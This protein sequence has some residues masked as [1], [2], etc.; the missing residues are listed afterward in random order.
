M[1]SLTKILLV[2][3]LITSATYTYAKPVKT[4]N[5]KAY[6]DTQD[7][8]LSGF[9]AVDAEGSFDVYIT[10][11]SVESVKVE[12]PTAA[13]EYIVTEVVDGTLRIHNKHNHQSNKDWNNNKK[14]KVYVTVRDI[15][16]IG[17]S[18]SGDAFFKDGIHADNLKIRVSGS[19]D[20]YGTIE[21]KE[22]T[23]SISGSGNMKLNGHAENST[24]SVSG[25]GNYKGGDVSTSSTT[26]QVSGSGNATINASNNITA[27]VSGSGDV[28]YKGGAQHVIKSKS[29]SGDISED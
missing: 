9:N 1:K 24:V 27:A 3:A 29:G 4:T 21:T 22:L 17:V 13:M 7:R 26:V 6:Y 20:V 19:G 2:A 18:G 10:Q 15:D 25:S 8:H 5:V 28:R 14:V 23:C 11:G 16:A 12:A